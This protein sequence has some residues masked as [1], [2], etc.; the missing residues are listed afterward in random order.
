MQQQERLRPGTLFDERFRVETLAG[1]G[2]M[3]MVYR[4]QD[5]TSGQLVAIKL[6]HDSGG[7]YDVDR[8]QRESRLLSELTHPAIV[9]Y[10][11]HGRSPE[12]QPYLVMEWLHGE[13]LAQRLS[14]Q[15][16]TVAESL[17]LLRLVAAALSE[18]HERSIIHRDLKPSNLFLR[19]GKVEGVTLLDFG[20]A[21]RTGLD[22]ITGTGVVIGTPHYM[23]PEQARGH[24]DLTPAS[25][26]FALGCVLYECLL[27]RAPFDGEHVGIVL[28]RILQEEPARLRSVRPEMPEQLEQLL[29][30]MLQKDVAARPAD[31]G[32]LLL[33]LAELEVPA[34][35]A[36]PA[37]QARSPEQLAARPLDVLP[38]RMV[39][40]LVVMPPEDASGGATLDPQSAERRRLRLVSLQRTM[41]QLGAPAEMMP[42]GSL[43]ATLAGK[44]DIAATTVKDWAA[45]AARLALGVR[46]SWPEARVM[47]A[48]GRGLVSDRIPIGEVVER[49]LRGLRG[50]HP[51]ARTGQILLDEVT[52]GLLDGRFIVRSD[53]TGS[54]ALEGAELSADESRPL[55]GKPTPCVGRDAE[56]GM[57]EA[58]L[59][60][61]I[62]EPRARAMLVTAPPGIGKSRLRHEFLRRVRGQTPEAV[63]MLGRGDSLSIGTPYGLLGQGLRQLCEIQEGETADCRRA[64]L[65]RR[66]AVHVP[67]AAATR[68]TLFLGELIGLPFPD[69]AGGIL[70]AARQDPQV[71]ADQTGLAWVEF[72]A[73]ECG[74]HPVVLVLEDLHWGDALTVKLCRLALQ[75]LKNQPLCVLA[76]GRPE[77]EALL[78]K[79][80]PELTQR[81]E[82]RPLS[83]RACEKLTRLMLGAQADAATLARIVEQ[84]AGHALFLE[85][86]IR[87]VADGKGSLLPK[88]VLAIL[89]E[90]IERLEARSQRALCAASVF[91]ETCWLGGIRSLLGRLGDGTTLG[92]RMQLLCRSE[93]L[94]ERLSS[95]IPGEKEYHF[96]HALMRDA[97]YELLSAEDRTSC[98][99]L[100]GQYLE[101]HG[102][103]DA[104]KLAEHFRRG[105][106]PERAAHYYLKAAD[107]AFE[108]LDRDTAEAHAEHGL[109]CQPQGELR[110]ALL[111]TKLAAG[112]WRENWN[113]TLAVGIA[114]L[115]LLPQ[116]S[117]RWCR[118]ISGL[119]PAALM[120]RQRE[121][122]GSL[123][124]R[125]LTVDPEPAGLSA[126]ILASGWYMVVSAIGGDLR[127]FQK[128]R[129]RIQKLHAA[130]AAD[131]HLTQGYFLAADATSSFLL[132]F[133]PGRSL[134]TSLD[135][136]QR[137][138]DGGDRHLLCVYRRSYGHTL[139]LLGRHAEAE[140]VLRDALRLAA[141]IDPGF[142]AMTLPAILAALLTAYREE[143]YLAE[144]EQLARLVLNGKNPY[145]IGM[146]C[147]VL[148]Q[149]ACRRGDLADA[150]SWARR[151]CDS[152]R[153]FGG[154]RFEVDAQ[155]IQVLL[156]RN[157]LESAQQIAAE[158]LA[159]YQKLGIRN[160]A[161]LGLFLAAAQAQHAGGETELARATL[162]TA[163]QRLKSY[164]EAIP[165]PTLRDS[166]LTC[167]PQ[168][169][170]I[171]E[172]T[173]KWQA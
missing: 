136:A 155:L 104:V 123:V 28:M 16:L 32:A 164:A 134:R 48:T 166:Y 4:A 1:S 111:G 106:D 66:V 142:I 128:F 13:D 146:A 38:E 31:A 149:L 54:F 148:S 92:V 101:A 96:R 2:G 133:D 3:G 97:A 61:C 145:P 130:V 65:K 162:G 12:G 30:R 86:L 85:E 41:A 9:R 47:L 6:F 33:L 69:D 163:L 95:V 70:R 17:L 120:R 172:L 112:V 36:G 168:N 49:A 74:A 58:T 52:A 60:E 159:A 51:A 103:T 127:S 118:L 29:D 161:E 50:S 152:V 143:P 40:V 124:E 153:P 46:D 173:V 138:L 20:V 67:A 167:V 151:G 100:A 25:D 113:E 68:V 169:N 71:M 116:G 87:A 77:V 8:F 150:E 94:Q 119:F 122:L 158:S 5:V 83:K 144:A 117:T 42:D 107:Q 114:A 91:G 39:S 109:S 165:D 11:A 14:R 170:L 18:A 115:D 137:F 132:E 108:A 75:R 19:D 141:Q 80:F 43:V 35:L 98:H 27:G 15:S 157:D 63:I 73:A 135:A 99:L 72:L 125:F 139:L 154:H 147:T 84:A 90:R 102:E 88:T 62:D 78:P 55:L 59:G 56:L 21:R 23:S 82:L 93:I 140:T 81:I 34:D 126:Y 22:G 131:D 156:Q 64:K 44:G 171:Q 110:G 76:L 7:A 37:T 89:Q 24:R 129:T 121:L 53:E 79:P 160:Y 45:Q 105:E 57:M 26:I 10:I